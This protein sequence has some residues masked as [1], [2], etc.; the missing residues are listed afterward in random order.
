MTS[1][2]SQFT[3]AMVCQGAKSQGARNVPRSV[4]NDACTFQTGGTCS[5]FFCFFFGNSSTFLNKKQVEKKL[6]E[7]RNINGTSRCSTFWKGD[8]GSWIISRLFSTL[9]PR[10]NCWI[11]CTSLSVPLDLT[12]VKTTTRRSPS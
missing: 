11:R 6:D 4:P 10:H 12:D 7:Q 3:S 9:D 5:R 8:L 1:L 2:Y